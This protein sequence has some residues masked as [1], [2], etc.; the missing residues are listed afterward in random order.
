MS[1]NQVQTNENPRDIPAASELVARAGSLAPALRKRAE[2]TERD[3]NIPRETVEE[4]R[5]TV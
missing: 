2:Q 3:R 1:G 5:Q 4:D